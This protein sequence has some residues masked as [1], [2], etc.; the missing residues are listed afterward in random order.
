VET[1]ERT[2]NPSAAPGELELVRAFVNTLD[3]EAG[4]D[5]LGTPE[6]A[7][8]WL[9]EHRHPV[10]R[11]PSPAELARLV[12]LREAIRDVAGSRGTS[13]EGPALDAFDRIAARHP[14]VLHLG[15]EGQ[16]LRP[17]GTGVE[18][19]IGRVLA[20]V[21]ASTLQGTWPRL[22][23]CPNDRCRWLFYDHSRNRTRM[24]CSMDV[25]GSRSKMRAYRARRRDGGPRPA[26]AS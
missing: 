25:C 3:I 24:W 14:F 22:K 10:E 12:A 2:E 18:G 1:L 20:I 15:V 21:A 9:S 7:R 4:T 11:R 13:A 23:S 6:G 5:L 8:D 19:F 26:P 16:P 17:A